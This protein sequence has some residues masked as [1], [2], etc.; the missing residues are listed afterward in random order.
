MKHS[1]IARCR[2]LSRRAAELG[3]DAT[4]CWLA[5]AR[6]TEKPGLLHTRSARS[7]R[8]DDDDVLVTQGARLAFNP[9]LNRRVID[10]AHQGRPGSGTGGMGRRVQE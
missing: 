7:L 10:A 4:G 8:P 2:N 9:T 1:R 6:L 5:S 3:D